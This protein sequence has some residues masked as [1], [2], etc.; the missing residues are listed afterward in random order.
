M[1]E[2]IKRIKGL[3]K[4]ILK[5][6]KESLTVDA[7]V[8][9]ELSDA[10]KNVNSIFY[11]ELLSIQY[12][13]HQNKYFAERGLLTSNDIAQTK[14]WVE[15]QVYKLCFDILND[16]KEK[17]SDFPEKT[18]KRMHEIAILFFNTNFAE[19]IDELEDFFKSSSS[20]Y[21]HDFKN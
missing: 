11:F 21:L 12:L 17:A 4:Y 9:N 16:L 18:I 2:E 14:K 13:F 1:K 10:C 8:L 20:Y 3:Q 5:F 15:K 7:Y 6:S 19:G